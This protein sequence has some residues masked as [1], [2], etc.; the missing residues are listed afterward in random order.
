MSREIK[1]KVWDNHNK[2]SLGVFGPFKHHDEYDLL[3]LEGKLEY[4]V[5][6]NLSIM[7]YTGLTDI[8]GD[9]IYED[10]ILSVA[11]PRNY[12]GGPYKGLQ[13]NHLRR[14]IWRQDNGGWVI[15]VLSEGLDKILV[16]FLFLV[17]GRAKVIGNFYETPELLP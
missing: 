10:D 5:E 15:Q 11:P 9:E 3:Y 4:P 14:V 8:D 17:A 12:K 13:I 6:D 1:F 16:K 2:H 7:Q